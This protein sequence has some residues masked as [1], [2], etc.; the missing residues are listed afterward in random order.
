M[1]MLSGVRKVNDTDETTAAATVTYNGSIIAVLQAGQ[2]ATLKCE[3]MKMQ[4]DVVVDSAENSGG[5]AIDLANIP[6]VDS[7]EEP[8]NTSPSAVR[9]NGEIYLLIQ[10]EN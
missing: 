5:G 1:A 2:T 6:E 10:E 3:G 7:I 4:S 9:Y 8:K